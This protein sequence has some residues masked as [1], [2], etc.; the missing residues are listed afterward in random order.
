[1]SN[2]TDKQIEVAVNWW[3]ELLNRGRCTWTEQNKNA[4]LNWD[5]GKCSLLDALLNQ[6]PQDTGD[7]SVFKF[8][9]QNE[10]INEEVV[11]YIGVDY[12]PTGDLSRALAMAGF[13]RSPF[14]FKTAMY[15]NKGGVQVRVGYGGETVELLLNK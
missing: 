10:L 1:M 4:E 6:L 15:F 11:T 2:L 8:S 9:L 12:H 14:P 7:V 5:T 13:K 3:A